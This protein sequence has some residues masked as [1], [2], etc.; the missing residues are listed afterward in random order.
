MAAVITHDDDGM[1]RVEFDVEELG[2]L[3]DHF[4]LANS[5]IFVDVE[6]EHMDLRETEEEEQ[7]GLVFA[8]RLCEFI[9]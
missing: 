1:D 4:L 7:V 6:V 5:L 9:V 2:L 8:L 3:G